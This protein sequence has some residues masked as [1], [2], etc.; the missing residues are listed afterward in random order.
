MAI[1]NETV[2]KVEEVK[3]QQEQETVFD[4]EYVQRQIQSATDKIKADFS[5]KL[6]D[7]DSELETFKKAQMTESERLQF[8][9][10]KAREEAEREKAIAYRERMISKLTREFGSQNLPID[11]VDFAIDVDEERTD[12]KKRTLI[13][14]LVK[15]DKETEKRVKEQLLKSSVNPPNGKPVES[16]EEFYT[17]EQIEKLKPDDYEKNRDKVYKSLERMRVTK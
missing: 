16:S 2:E 6:K 8:E 12:T 10:K 15:R 3:G 4:A 1:E 13:D 9:A 14:I 11:L 17:M 5:K 7:K